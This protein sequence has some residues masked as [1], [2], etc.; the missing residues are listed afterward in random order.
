VAL[1]LAALVKHSCD[2]IIGATLDGTITSWNSGAE[3]IYGYSVAEIIGSPFTTLVPPERAGEGQE[4]K[5]RVE[6]GEHIRRLETVRMRKDGTRVDVSITVSPI[7]DVTDKLVG[8]SVVARDITKRKRSEQFLRESEE[9]F[10]V[11]ADTAPVMIWITDESG[12]HTFFNRFFLEFTGHTLAEEL[13]NG[14]NDSIHPE[15][16]QLCWKTVQTALS[17]RQAYTV[18][19]RFR[20]S[21]GEYRWVLETGVPR[22]A[23]NGDFLG[24]IGSCIDVTERK[25]AEL[26]VRG[27]RDELEWEVS[28]QSAE[29]AE[30]TSRLIREIMKREHAEELLR[31]PSRSN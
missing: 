5:E 13:R 25:W 9:R 30:A 8:V 17:K 15:D 24:Y 31:N 6:R 29:L 11:M 12:N 10:R 23:T 4:L 28:E 22:P 1:R 27:S 18:E 7:K 3:Q 21:D 14:W 20:K 26:A 2:A 19:Y 16:R